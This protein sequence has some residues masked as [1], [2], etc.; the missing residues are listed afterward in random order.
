MTNSALTDRRYVY[1][2]FSLNEYSTSNIEVV[3]EQLTE[4]RAKGYTRVDIEARGDEYGYHELSF[5]VVR[6]RLENDEEYAKRTEMDEEYRQRRYRE[7]LRMCKEFGHDPAP[8]E[9]N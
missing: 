7:Y 1:D 2:T 6:R 4:L 3:I 9:P 8:F 5:D